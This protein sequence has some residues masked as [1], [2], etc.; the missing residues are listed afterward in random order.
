MKISSRQILKEAGPKEKSRATGL[1]WDFASS[2]LGVGQHPKEE[3]EKYISENSGLLP[4]SIE[5]LESIERLNLKDD[6]AK[7]VGAD[8]KFFIIA[9]AILDSSSE[10]EA[11][12][13]TEEV[14]WYL[15][16]KEL[17]PNKIKKDWLSSNQNVLSNKSLLLEAWRKF[18]N[19]VRA[20][21]SE[22]EKQSLD[23]GSADYLSNQVVHD[24][25]DGWKVVYVPAVGEIKEFPGLPNTS[26][27]RVLEGNK[28]GL[29]LGASLKLYQD[30]ST[31]KIYSIRDSSN[32]P[33]VTIRIL[34]GELEEAKGKNNLSPEIAAAK[35]AS[36]WFEILEKKGE[37]DFRNSADYLSFP[38]LTIE[39]AIKSFARSEERFIGSGWAT[40]WYKNGIS[41]L[42]SKIQELIEKK[43][44]L[45]L[46]SS[47]NKKYA[48]LVLPVYLYHSELY[49]S[50]E[51]SI[52]FPDGDLDWRYQ[53][54]AES[55]FWKTYR[56]NPTIYRAISAFSQE[57]YSLFL[58][59]GIPKD[60]GY[61]NLL[62]KDMFSQSIES[63]NIPVNDAFEIMKQYPELKDIAVINNIYATPYT[64]YNFDDHTD[65]GFYN[66]DEDSEA[67]LTN[68][69]EFCGQ[70]N[71]DIFNKNIA[72]LADKHING[73]ISLLS[74]KNL[75]NSPCF[76]TDFFVDTLFD[77]LEEKYGK[78]ELES[79][80][81]YD[82][83]F[84]KIKL[85]KLKAQIIS[86]G[87]IGLIEKVKGRE[88]LKEKIFN[89]NVS[90]KED[91]VTSLYYYFSPEMLVDIIKEYKDIVD[92]KEITFQ[93]GTN[94]LYFYLN[95]LK[96]KPDSI[97]SSL[98]TKNLILKYMAD[99]NPTQITNASK[100]YSEYIDKEI[101]DTAIK[102]QFENT[103]KSIGNY[104][105]EFKR[106]LEHY[107]ESFKEYKN[108]FI[109][110]AKKEILNNLN[111]KDY[112][113]N[114]HYY[115]WTLKSEIL[116]YAPELYEAIII[117]LIKNYPRDFFYYDDG[118]AQTYL[119]NLNQYNISKSVIHSS[120]LNLA[121][122]NP[123]LF[124][125]ICK[126]R[127][128]DNEKISIIS[129]S[130]ATKYPIIY[131]QIYPLANLPKNPTILT[132]R[133]KLSKLI[134]LLDNLGLKKEAS[135]IN[136]VL[137]SATPDWLTEWRDTMRHYGFQ[138]FGRDTK[139]HKG[140]SNLE[141]P[142]DRI[143]AEQDIHMVE[144]AHSPDAEGRRISDKRLDT[145]MREFYGENIWIAPREG[146]KR[147]MSDEE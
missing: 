4:I 102:Q 133:T 111:V 42:D 121:L 141:E 13:K 3:I 18:L 72:H 105:S 53:K 74:R 113:K 146:W 78:L 93:I 41:N 136:Q 8:E 110:R 43:D 2:N 81:D 77:S 82:A 58:K 46:E 138:N 116:D 94:D 28:N 147:K 97:D 79:K 52:L 115:Y 103:I 73:F 90:I 117:F 85:L 22:S 31:G 118:F 98:E 140:K 132:T 91:S 63:G 48:E 67:F 44:P 106:T 65:D 128:I 129:Q 36:E 57:N 34:A 127:M 32:K 37:L 143:S 60:E 29:C 109:S 83:H 21:K 9:S 47:L 80:L 99:L 125:E 134:L 49:L 55:E 120:L 7:R 112:I 145:F 40:H 23:S 76:E 119:N 50:G 62:S 144:Q 51:E 35:K 139:W 96:N 104:P 122:D 69:V 95:L 15:E 142:M 92:S 70:M 20:V 61:K 126:L 12:A 27:D 16:Y 56:K 131:E 100:D 38:P 17:S 19:E 26:H 39:D 130:L 124:A 1:N 71:R 101:L 108:Y 64:L 75:F 68:L 107:I 5:Q 66:L 30:N 59:I 33:K 137:S 123:K 135:D 10:S 87:M 25:G 45:I 14:E 11:R 86:S 6:A 54:I 88:F 89:D 84:F 114:Y 24:F